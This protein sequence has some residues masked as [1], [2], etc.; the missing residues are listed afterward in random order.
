MMNIIIIMYTYVN[1]LID[2]FILCQ[3]LADPRKSQE[4]M[5]FTKEIV[6]GETAP[7]MREHNAVIQMQ[8]EKLAALNAELERLQKEHIETIN[9]HAKEIK[10]IHAMHIQ[11]LQGLRTPE[12]GPG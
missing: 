6:R 2:H 3:A 8:A 10:N 11:E 4:L 5:E 9:A 12:A 7:L 1:D